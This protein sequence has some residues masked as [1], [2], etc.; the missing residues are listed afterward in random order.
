VTYDSHLTDDGVVQ[1]GR[2]SSLWT[3]SA[4]GWR[5]RFHQSTV[6]P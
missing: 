3:R 5:L 2:R 1:R 4:G 6:I